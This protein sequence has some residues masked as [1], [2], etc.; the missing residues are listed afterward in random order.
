MKGMEGRCR[1]VSTSALSRSL[2]C[3]R[4]GRG[5]WGLRAGVNAA[6][7]LRSSLLLFLSSLLRPHPPLCLSG[8]MGQPRGHLSVVVEEAGG[9]DWG[10]GYLPS[11]LPWPGCPSPGWAQVRGASEDWPRGTVLVPSNFLSPVL[12]CSCPSNFLPFCV[13]LCGAGV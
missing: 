5:A 8:F 11:I 12:P 10:G 3:P 4:A 7:S 13:D 6:I 2:L 9:V 1:E